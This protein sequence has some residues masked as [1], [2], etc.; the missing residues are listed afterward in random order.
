M[1]ST[2]EIPQEPC[3]SY[4]KG[5]LFLFEKKMIILSS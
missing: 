3:L 2:G 5:A 4:S 1:I